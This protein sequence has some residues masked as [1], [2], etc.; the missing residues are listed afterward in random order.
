MYKYMIE[1]ICGYVFGALS[2]AVTR[3]KNKLVSQGDRALVLATT[4]A[5]VVIRHLTARASI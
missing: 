5:I 2:V 1:F 4:S 3:V